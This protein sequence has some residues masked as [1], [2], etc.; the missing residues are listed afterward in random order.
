MR[1]ID[2]LSLVVVAALAA[3]AHASPQAVKVNAQREAY[4][5]DLH[6]HTSYSMDAYLDGN[7]SVG[8][9]EAYRFAKGEVVDYLG[10]PVKRREPLDFMAV[11]DHAENLGV[12]NTLKDPDSPAFQSDMAESFKALQAMPA[13]RPDMEQLSSFYDRYLFGSKS[14]S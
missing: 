13:D 9:D 10:E 12:L 1:K 7:T 4:Y 5:G 14:Q 6:L 3:A 2:V 8:P 11:T